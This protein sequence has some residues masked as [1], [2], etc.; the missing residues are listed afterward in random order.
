[1]AELASFEIATRDTASVA[2]L[3]G[4]V[5]AS[6]AARLTQEILEQVP[7][8]AIGLALDLREVS[9]LDSAGVHM[10]IKLSSG[11]VARGQQLRLVVGPDAF[12][13]EVLALAGLRATIP[14]DG[15]LE[16]ALEA[17]S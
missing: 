13:A 12:A 15:T 16:Q 3:G 6:N 4:E 11:L 5:D 8:V 7:N 10:L 9:Y 14:V 17:L 2:R 1:M